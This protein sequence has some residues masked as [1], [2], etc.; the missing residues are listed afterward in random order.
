MNEGA[1][2]TAA[3]AGTTGA[4]IGSDSTGNVSGRV[5][6]WAISAS[7]S[8]TGAGALAAEGVEGAEGV[9][10]AGRESSLRSAAGNASA[11][12]SAAP[13]RGA[14]RSSDAPLRSVVRAARV[15]VAVDSDGALDGLRTPGST[16][17]D[18]EE[19]A[20]PA[21]NVLESPVSA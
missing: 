14:E 15:P 2:S 1:G 20:G 11:S 18:V 17:W 10:S 7:G 13:R 19:F 5:G 21:E 3:D 4:A 8:W 16:D 12:G 9:E 6:G